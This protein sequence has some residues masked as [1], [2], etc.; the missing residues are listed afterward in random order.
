MQ[1]FN[2]NLAGESKSGLDMFDARPRVA[3]RRRYFRSEP[4]SDSG[5]GL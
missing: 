3:I 5:K 2:A 4:V 1:T